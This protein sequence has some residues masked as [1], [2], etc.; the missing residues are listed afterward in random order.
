MAATAIGFNTNA[1]DFRISGAMGKI[2]GTVSTTSEGIIKTGVLVVV[3]TAAIS[4]APPAISSQTLTGM[5]YY[6]ANSYED[7]TY[8]A[9]VRE[10][11]EDYNVYAYY[12]S[13][14]GDTPVINSSS[15]ANVSVTAGST[16]ANVN[17]TWP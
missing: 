3:T 10:S 7:G 11:A 9:E 2:T 14:T 15:T 17:F 6:M 13:F 1:G 8:S 12:F 4:G 5:P 16:T